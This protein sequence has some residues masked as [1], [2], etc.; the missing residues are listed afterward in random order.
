MRLSKL[1]SE[2][3][4]RSWRC[5][6]FRRRTAAY[7]QC[8]MAEWQEPDEFVC[9]E[10]PGDAIA[11]RP[12]SWKSAW[13]ERTRARCEDEYGTPMIWM[14]LL[15][16]AIQLILKWWLSRRDAQEMEALCTE[17]NECAAKP[18]NPGG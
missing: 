16:L 1:E 5:R 18:R 6:L 12:N 9:G 13:I 8:A 11:N 2:V 4:A 3:V 10:L 7:I 14:W 15:S 17:A